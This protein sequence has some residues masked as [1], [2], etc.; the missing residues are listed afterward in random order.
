[1]KDDRTDPGSIGDG[2]EAEATFGCPTNLDELSVEEA[3]HLIRELCARQVE[4]LRANA[5]LEREITD[6]RHRE[7]ELREREKT[8]RAVVEDQTELIF[9]FLPD[10]TLMLVNQAVCDYLGQER[11][12][13]IGQALPTS[14]LENEWIS[15]VCSE[16]PVV[17]YEQRK[18]MPN[19]GTYWMRWIIRGLWGGEGEVV[20]Y[21]V[22]GRNI[23][24][25]KRGE[26]RLAFQAH[27]LDQVRDAVIA[28]DNEL[29][30]TYLNQS[31][32]ERYDLDPQ[33]SLGQKLS[34]LF[35]YEWLDPEDGKAVSASLSAEGS[36][37]GESV[38]VKKDGK[39]IFVDSSISLLRDAAGRNAGML[40][41]VRDVSERRE[42]QLERARLLAQ[43][44]EDR[45]AVQELVVALERERALL[46]TIMEHTHAQLAYLD[47][48]FNFVRVNAAYARGSGYGVEDLVGQNHFAVFPD[49]ENQAIFERVRDTGQPAEFQAKPFVFPERPELGTTY[50]DWTLMPV[51]GATGE[52]EGFVLSLLDV[53][54]RERNRSEREAQWARQSLLVE[55]SQR[56]LEES[57]VQGI[58][59][60]AVDAACSLCGAQ[61]AVSGFVSSAGRFEIGPTYR[62][63]GVPPCLPGQAFAIERGG[64]HLDLLQGRA[65]LRLTDEEMRR[66]PGWWGLPEGHVPL[67]GFLGARLAGSDGQTA[68][69]IMLSDKAEGNFA[70]GDEALMVQLASLASLGLQHIKAREEAER[71]VEE[72]DTVFDAMLDAVIV[73]GADGV[74]TRANRVAA[75][76]ADTDPVGAHRAEL[77][78]AF[79]T[80]TVDGRRAAVDD[81]PSARALRGETVT[82]E[83]YVIRSARG[84]DR[85]VLSS[86]SPLWKDGTISGAVL[87]WHDVTE[88]DRLL[89]ENRSQREFLERLMEA[90]PVGIAV[91]RGPDHRYEYANPCYQAIPGM[92]VAGR[93][94]AEVF[95]PVAAQRVVELVEQVY[96]TGETTGLRG[97]EMT[98]GPG[99]ART[100]WNI[101]H[102]PL[103][104]SGE[105]GGVLVL[106][107]EVTEPVL[108]RR[109]LEIERARLGAIIEN[110]PEG[111]IV[112]D[113]DCRISLTNPAAARI[114][115]RSVQP[116]QDDRDCATLPL[117]YADGIPCDPRDLPLT[118]A[119]LDGE[120]CRNLEMA[121]LWP[122]GSQRDL[123]V[124]AT[125]IRDVENTITG[126]VQILHDVSELKQ[127]QRVLRLYA[128]RLEFLREA[129]RAILTSQSA[130][131]MATV[132]LPYLR[133]LAPCTWASVTTF[134]R[135][136]DQV[137]LLAA[138]AEGEIKLQTEWRR[139]LEEVWF[140]DQLGPGQVYQDSEPRELASSSLFE[141]FGGQD[142][143]GFASVPLVYQGQVIG[144]LNL[145]LGTP[146]PLTQ[147]QVD[148]LQQIATQ[149]TIG[150]RQAELHDQV[151]RH[152]DELEQIVTQRTAALR[153]SQARLQAI[154]DGAPLGIVLVGGDGRI[155]QSN[156]AFGK[157]LGYSVDELRGKG[158]AELTHPDSVYPDLDLFAELMADR[159]DRY[160]L[161]KRYVRRDG[162]EV[163]V[164]LSVTAI[165]AGEGYPRLALKMV[166]D[167]TERRQ[168]QQALVQAEKLTATGRLAAS[169]AHEINNP[170][171]A[172][173]GCLDLAEGALAEGGDAGRYLEVAQR[174]LSRAARVVSQ[175]RDLHR[176]SG[177]EERQPVDVNALVQHVLEVTAGQCKRRRVEVEWDGG[178]LA[179]IPGVSDQLQQL[180]LNLILN[181][182]DA[183][184]KGGL[185]KISTA[186]TNAPD[187]VEVRLADTGVG[188]A[189]DDLPHL[190][191]PFY[192]TRPDGMGLGL[193]VSRNIVEHHGGRIEAKSEAGQGTTF[194][195][196]LPR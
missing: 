146:G 127:T 22:E 48:Q 196:W 5:R 83:R 188:I 142:R 192:T 103:L 140:L 145:G 45:E 114:Y 150:V 122:D 63:E 151:Q 147:E 43:S 101:D 96:R 123:L 27:A 178:A 19:G 111:V 17:T 107:S 176:R 100:C 28:I 144:S 163:W 32:L 14:M 131:E 36:W 190:F 85:I 134:D 24:E 65:S 167:I 15:A 33:H 9:R 74:V 75:G 66:Y 54:A 93:T 11:G 60:R 35:Q 72:L 109:Q 97:Y 38:H 52:V 94:I 67:R 12:A 112:S 34:D 39:R 137:T 7:A 110:A 16:K 73:Y 92:Q 64:V 102:V 174:E 56:I 166:E 116:E 133:Q 158:F 58:L 157:I 95:P 49:A 25:R 53:T 164:A 84:K 71:H 26:E 169:L 124:S 184:P 159:R 149:L 98:V 51:R 20:G 104:E 161:E 185:L 143:G 130:E 68:G 120:T 37:R 46:D 153:V 156:P 4:L 175:L 8:Y 2:E 21:Q 82:E 1:M 154:Y 179:P 31:A 50:W 160:Q 106:A 172:V 10:G 126:A 180:F 117:W 129:D 138:S 81:L 186:C 42:Q 115:G 193:Y 132:V 86:A 171:Q 191:E 77:I 59:R 79:M 61:L 3:R 162:R 62:A 80:R 13:L 177:A 55:V 87:L 187:G 91:V 40:A 183:M 70:A 152:A 88:Q 182:V 41:I 6:N 119:A 139:P 189:A 23:T 76:T 121:L 173:I 141:V 135:Q 69:V 194:T 128:D 155:I 170:L 136:T 90:A 168:A 78:Q 118:R 108:A 30:V 44:M 125:P 148:G 195:V 105:V 89:A 165:R 18:E 181:A 29:R 99:R 47:P 113:S 57:S